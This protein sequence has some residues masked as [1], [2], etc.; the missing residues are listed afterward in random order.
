M[1]LT[2]PSREK[3]GAALEL[4]VRGAD[5][6]L[7]NRDGETALQSALA[8]GKTECAD[9]VSDFLRRP[10]FEPEPGVDA[11]VSQ[12][13][14]AA[15][16]GR[17]G[18]MIG[19]TSSAPEVCRANTIFCLGRRRRRLGARVR[20]GR[21][22]G[23]GV[24]TAAAEVGLGVRRGA[25]LHVTNPCAGTPMEAFV[26]WSIASGY[27]PFHGEGAGRERDDD[28]EEESQNARRR[29]GNGSGGRGTAAEW[30]EHYIGVY[31]ARYLD[32]LSKG[33][34]VFDIATRFHSPDARLT[35]E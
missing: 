6:R 10:T 22:L 17:S 4:L 2:N 1:R 20:P 3:T 11:S 5:P 32:G 33:S 35:N 8:N 29:Y 18:G 9:L 14:V 7:R 27:D 12:N 25:R 23:V 28:D 15:G 21:G 24:G 34:P 13:V 16:D 19:G 26:L 31:N 30:L